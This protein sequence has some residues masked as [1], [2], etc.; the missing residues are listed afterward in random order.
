MLL[1]PLFYNVCA[2][3]T[4]NGPRRSRQIKHLKI[5]DDQLH[6][7][8]QI[9]NEQFFIYLC[10]PQIMMIYLVGRSGVPQGKADSLISVLERGFR[11]TQ[12]KEALT[13]DTLNN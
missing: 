3:N 11:E 8:L 6:F 4:A 13:G 9:N 7:K 5:Q 1:T 2:A 12:N 10:P